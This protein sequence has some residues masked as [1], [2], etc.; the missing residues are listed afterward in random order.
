[1]KDR[2]MNSDGYI[3]FLVNQSIPVL[4]KVGFTFPINDIQGITVHVLE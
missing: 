1:M 3:N 2:N 4:I